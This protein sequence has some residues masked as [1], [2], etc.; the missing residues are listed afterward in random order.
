MLQSQPLEKSKMKM[1]EQ[2]KKALNPPKMKP[3]KALSMND[4]LKSFLHSSVMQQLDRTPKQ[5]PFVPLELPGGSNPLSLPFEELNLD[6]TIRLIP[7]PA[8]LEELN[9]DAVLANPLISPPHLPF[10]EPEPQ[11]FEQIQSI[12]K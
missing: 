11:F 6:T 7:G 4:P 10:I 5:L 8:T 2:T 9:R 12:Q 3:L 1:L